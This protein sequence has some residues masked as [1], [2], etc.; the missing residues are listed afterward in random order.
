MPLSD[1]ILKLAFERSA[2][3]PFFAGCRLDRLRR[4]Q[5]LTPEQQAEALGLTLESL[6]GLCLCRQPRDKADVEMIAARMGWEAGRVADLLGVR[7][8]T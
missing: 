3:D 1:P 7:L 4:D 6:V 2:T 5:R 8:S